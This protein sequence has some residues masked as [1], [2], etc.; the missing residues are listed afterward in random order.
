MILLVTWR[1]TS[2]E[3][4]TNDTHL[5]T[6]MVLDCLAMINQSEDGFDLDCL[7]GQTAHTS[8]ILGKMCSLMS[9]LELFH[10]M[11]Q[12]LRWCPANNTWSNVAMEL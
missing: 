3:T 5:M 8:G 2:Q 12:T 7:A 9:F 10:F 1:K 6:Q 4:D 11:K